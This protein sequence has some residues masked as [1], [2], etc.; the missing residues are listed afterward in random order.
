MWFERTHS[1]ANAP[2]NFPNLIRKVAFLKSEFLKWFSNSKKLVENDKN[3]NCLSILFMRLE[4]AYIPQTGTYPHAHVCFDVERFVVICVVQCIPTFKI[5]SYL[6]LPC[7]FSFVMSHA[8]LKTC[9]KTIQ[10]SVFFMCR[11]KINEQFMYEYTCF[12]LSLS[13]P[14]HWIL[15]VLLYKV[16][17]RD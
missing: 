7:V 11:H 8:L 17:V 12:S 5:S 10:K 2:E 6:L 3:K 15:I 9:T 1:L 13:S 16:L 14:V 4:F